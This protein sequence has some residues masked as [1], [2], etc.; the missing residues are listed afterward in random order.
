MV[1][2]I[3]R[4]RKR[5]LQIVTLIELRL[6]DQA[7]REVQRALQQDPN[8][9]EAHRLLAWAL[10]KQG[11][12]SQARVSARTAVRLAPQSADAFSTLALIVDQL[13]WHA[14]AQKHHK[15]AI[16]LAPHVAIF[17]TRYANHFLRTRQWQVALQEADEALRLAPRHAGSLVIRAEAL[18]FLG[19]LSGAEESARKALAI[20]PNNPGAHQ[21]LGYIY[22]KRGQGDEAFSSFR[23]ALRLDPTN[24]DLKWGLIRAMEAK[25]PLFGTIRQRIHVIRTTSA[26]NW[27]IGFCLFYSFFMINV[28]RE[29]P[30][31]A[32]IAASIPVIL[33][34]GLWIFVRVTDWIVIRA[35]MKGWIK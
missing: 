25:L 11:K 18:R 3:T 1:V 9:A 34:I 27:A 8:D 24:E 31:I 29:H 17:H 30:G 4:L 13:G 5:Y 10:W 21:T 14:A 26:A 6:F 33:F 7:I 35:V 20:A 22:L 28:L 23:E 19:R 32:F 12:L 2:K 16:V 15:Q